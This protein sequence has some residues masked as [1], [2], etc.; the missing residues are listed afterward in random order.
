MKSPNQLH[1]LSVTHQARSQV[2]YLASYQS[3]PRFIHL[4]TKCL[5]QQSEQQYNSKN[6]WH[7]KQKFLCPKILRRLI[8]EFPQE[9]CF[10]TQ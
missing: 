3:N 1:K 6:I 8:S 9:R 7:P 4:V 2:N 5:M 10:L